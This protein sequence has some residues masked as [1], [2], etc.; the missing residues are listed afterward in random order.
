M[1]LIQARTDSS[2]LPAKVLLPISNINIIV[3]AVK[4]A[5]NTGKDVMVLTSI[6][7]SDNYL[8]NILSLNKIKYFRGSLNNV[9][10]RFVSSTSNLKGNDIVFRLTADNVF[11]DG[12]LIDEIEDDF[13]ERNLDYLVCNGRESGVPYGLSVEVTRVKFL[14]EALENANKKYDLEHVTPYIIRNCNIGVFSKY[15]YM[16]LGNY[17]CT[18]DNLEDYL[19][20]ADLFSKEADPCKI[21]W[22]SLVNILVDRYKYDIHS[23]CL[24]KMII[25]GAQFGMDYGIANKSGKPNIDVVGKIIKTAIS[26]GSAFIDTAGNYGESEKIIG[27]ILSSGWSGRV[28][29][30]TK[31]FIPDSL[32]FER[33][34]GNIRNF[35][36]SIV[37]KSCINLNVK[38]IDYLLLH[39]A[40]YLHEWN[41]YIWHALKELKSLGIVE[42]L[43][44]SIQTEKEFEESLALNDIELI[45]FPYNILENRFTKFIDKINLVK[46]RR[47]LKIHARSVFLQ[48]LL[49]SKNKNHWLKANVDDPKSVYSCIDLITK[50]LKRIS[51]ADLCLAYVRSKEWIDGVIVGMETTQQLLENLQYFNN[52]VLT[53]EEVEYIESIIPNMSINTLDPSKWSTK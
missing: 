32:E 36:F 51:V 50:S 12:S 24:D 45:Q 14:R 33:T 40:K 34:I 42:K 37:Y 35:V 27:D 49:L 41:G 7:E 22:K 52:S 47:S 48:G 8:C 17:R 38:K 21:S 5:A 31:F 18:I 4:R 30:I 29:V 11:P 1:I 6:K 39:D 13:I 28:C 10:D 9:L 46:E 53:K 26:N 3:L 16:E 44:I 20:I 19:T 23:N 25:G 43:G 2:R 15:Q